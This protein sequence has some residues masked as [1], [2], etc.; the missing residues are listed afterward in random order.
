MIFNHLRA[1]HPSASFLLRSVCILLSASWLPNCGDDELGAIDSGKA[2]AP[3]A[4]GRSNSS[5]GRGGTTNT[6]GANEG[7]AAGSDPGGA[8][9]DSSSGGSE[10]GGATNTGGTSSGGTSA[11]GGSVATGGTTSTGGSTSEPLPDPLTIAGPLTTSAYG[12]EPF[13]TP[14]S[15]DEVLEGTF[16]LGR[17]FFVG[18]WL[19][20]PD[21]GRPTLDGLGPVFHATS[22]V[23]CHPSSAR[24]PS[25]APS[26]TVA[27]GLLFRLARGTGDGGFEAGDPIFGGQLQPSALPGVPV[28]GVI[29]WT[30]DLDRPPG[31]SEFSPRPVFEVTTHASYGALDAETRLAARLSPQ[32]VGMGF[33]EHVSDE[34]IL[35][36]EDPFDL[37]QDGISGR[38]A[39][40]A[41]P[42]GERVGRFG[43]KAIHPTLRA[44]TSAAFAGDI[45][46]TSP[47]HPT[48][49]CTAS[50]TDCLAQPNGGNPEFASGSIE[51]IDEFMTYLAVP[52]ARRSNDDAN[53]L[54]GNELF[55]ALGCSSCHRPHMQ[56][57]ELASFPVLSN[58]V[59]Y[60][61]TDL[62]LHDLGAQLS[63][64]LGEGDAEAHEWRTPPLWGLGL[65]D[66]RPNARY[67]HD[68]RATS[69]R[70]A[71]L[72]HGGEAEAARSAF[73]DLTETEKN[74]LLAFLRSL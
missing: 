3:S 48:D 11:T 38:A 5:G 8:G 19:R 59:F 27:F 40:L 32:I 45:G 36:W 67:L 18:D 10:S 56:L 20:A 7:G 74:Q 63:D 73:F 58:V 14:A 35:A 29:R 69:L 24:A 9:G 30:A 4:G 47:E 72:W 70:D 62:L 52:A 25:L 41:L 60:A 50:Q 39:R 13:L 54:A 6:G 17:E 71:I 44:Q 57:G 15:I 16:S 53:V 61:Y 34:E 31:V 12:G 66:Q 22:C 1:Q 33:F 2:D 23:A 55:F 46:I 51:A 68:G 64:D 26:D 42:G 21:A 37:D 49:D 43:W 28:E 65:V